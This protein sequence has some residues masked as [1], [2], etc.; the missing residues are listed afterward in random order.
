MADT[1]ISKKE[2]WFQRILPALSLMVLAPLIAEV[3]PGATRMSSM[4]VLPI[5]ILVWGGAAVLIRE[6]V[7]RLRLGWL[8]MLLLAVA[9]SVAEECLIQQTSLAP[10]VIKL[11]DVEYARAYGVNYVYFLW[12]LIYESL[13]V[14]FIP[15]GLAE[16]IFHDK[17]EQGWLNAAGIAIVSLL[18]I[19]GCLFAWFT[20]TQIARTKVFH[21]DAYT[22]PP[23]QMAIAAASIAILIALAIGP[24]RQRLVRRPSAIRPPHP[25]LL[26]ALSGIATVAIFGLTLLGFGISPTFPPLIAVAIGAT[27]IVLM[28]ASLPRFYAHESWSTWHQVGILYGAITTNMAVFFIAFIGA[29]PLDFYGK[30]VLNAIAVVLML[31]LAHRLK[32]AQEDSKLTPT[33]AR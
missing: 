10:M 23:N 29:T 7:R 28:I 2:S 1:A 4:F 25:L 19:P 12:A 32:L 14:V 9:L 21:L 16:L 8:N 5:E 33:H 24:L 22:P 3:L 31:W 18:F 13:F 27:L 6:A 15:I 17:R 26:A 20:W 11:K 30:V